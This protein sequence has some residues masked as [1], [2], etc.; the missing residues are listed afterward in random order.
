MLASLPDDILE[1]I[2]LFMAGPEREVD[3]IARDAVSASLTC[4][5]VSALGHALWKRV[6]SVAGSMDPS[7]ECETRESRCVQSQVVLKHH[8]AVLAKACDIPYASS[9]PRYML[10]AK[11][12]E[13]DDP[14]GQHCPIARSAALYVLHMK[15]RR[16]ASN[17]AH[18]LFKDRD[19]SRCRSNGKGYLFCDL[20]R[21]PRSTQATPVAR[22]RRLQQLKALDELFVGRK[23]PWHVRTQY[24]ADA[25][26]R[27]EKLLGEGFPRAVSTWHSEADAYKYRDL[28]AG[29]GVNMAHFAHSYGPYWHHL[30]MHV[31]DGLPRLF[32]SC[33][34]TNLMSVV[35][36]EDTRYLVPHFDMRDV[37]RVRELCAA[38]SAEIADIPDS[39]AAEARAGMT[40]GLPLTT[41]QV[42]SAVRL[43]AE[44]MPVTPVHWDLHPD[45]L[46]ESAEWARDMNR[47]FGVKVS[48]SFHVFVGDVMTAV[49][50]EIMPPP[51]D[52]CHVESLLDKH[53]IS[54]EDIED[55]KRQVREAA[56]LVAN[57]DPKL[58]AV[59]RR[60]FG[61]SLGEFVSMVT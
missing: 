32:R 37:V 34:D 47:E 50:R 8:V 4:R 19:L 41:R 6:E 43:H 39:I 48:N 5:G 61:L 49:M 20:R 25:L 52:R 40:A 36:I 56:L 14:V 16:M 12:Q 55:A 33:S 38:R 2:S 30:R 29:L 3:D 24:Q 44:G 9:L 57:A 27:K 10:D 28:C 46:R 13:S 17:D 54:L 53:M 15:L 45:S 11:L 22:Q 21:A 59:A 35:E 18:F 7:K 31:Q 1:R 60:T 23:R 51:F 26:F 42:V 58:L